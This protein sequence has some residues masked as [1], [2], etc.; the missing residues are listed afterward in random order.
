MIP[1]E[2]PENCPFSGH[3]APFLVHFLGIL[4]VIPAH[5]FRP[6]VRTH[7]RIAALARRRRL[8]LASF[9]LYSLVLVPA[10]CSCQ[11]SS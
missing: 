1:L 11:V 2:T 4:A 7:G 3:L 8:F 9:R 10:S 5:S 6:E